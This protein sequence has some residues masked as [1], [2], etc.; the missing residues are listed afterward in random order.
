MTDAIWAFFTALC[1]YRG[2]CWLLDWHP[3][4]LFQITINN[5][6]RIDD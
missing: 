4:P 5:Q 6:T 2:V 3:L 1:V